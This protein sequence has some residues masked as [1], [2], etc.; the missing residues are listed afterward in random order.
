MR[1]R[2][3]LM[4][5]RIEQEVDV[6]RRQCRRGRGPTVRAGA[7]RRAPRYSQQE[8]HGELRHLGK[9]HATGRRSWMASIRGAWI[10]G[11]E[12]IMGAS[13]FR[14]CFLVCP[15][16]GMLKWCRW[17]CI[18]SALRYMN[19]ATITIL[20][21]TICNNDL[22]PTSLQVK[23]WRSKSHLQSTLLAKMRLL[24]FSNDII[25]CWITI[26]LLSL[27]SWR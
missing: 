25:T 10:R 6:L 19:W 21:H 14:M 11:R 22:R 7:A 17:C 9:E 13:T 23:H 26:A 5:L 2:T 20:H 24:S 8:G 3:Y 16:F 18:S 27:L 15:L 1:A 4:Q 12:L